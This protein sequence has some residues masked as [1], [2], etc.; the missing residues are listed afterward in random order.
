MIDEIADAL[1]VIPQ[2]IYNYLNDSDIG[3][4]T[5]EIQGVTEAEWRL[6]AALHF[7]EEIERLEDIETDLLDRTT[8][9]STDFEKQSVKG[10]PTR[11]G[12]V[13]LADEDDYSLI[14]PVPSEYEEITDY[15][16]DLERIQIEKRNHADQIITLLR[17][18]D[19]DGDHRQQ[20]PG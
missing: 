16:S 2:Q 1:D 9:A 10:T 4:E 17:L 13:I 12:Q 18:D 7:R 15:G 19:H 20:R 14:I 5:R 3:R 11:E 6:D 8:T